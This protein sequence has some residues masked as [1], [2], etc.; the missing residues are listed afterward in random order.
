MESRVDGYTSELTALLTILSL[1]AIF[2]AVLGYFPEGLF[3]HNDALITVIPHLNAAIS[4]LAIGT[5]LYGVRAIRREQVQ[6]HRLAMLT[7]TVLFAGFLA[8]YLYRA[9]LEGPTAYTGPA[10]I[11]QFVYLPILAIHILLAIV[12]YLLLYIL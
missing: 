7:T 2:G 11:K 9:S 3:P 5:I 6:R 10:V 1:G 12:V 8:L 4:L